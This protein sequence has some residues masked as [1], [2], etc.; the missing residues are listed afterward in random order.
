MNRIAFRTPGRRLHRIAAITLLGLG[1]CASFMDD[2]TS[3][4]FEFKSLYSHP[5]PLVVL[6]DSTDGNERAKALRSL[7]EPKQ[8]GGTD[9]EQDAVVNILVTAASN[10]KQALCRLAAIQS[11][12][13]FQDPRAAQGLVS[14]FDNAGTFAPDTR[15]IV[16]CQA[17]RAMGEAHN[18]AAI[19]RLVAVVR[20]PPVAETQPLAEKRQAL[21]IRIAAARALG[22]F[23]EPQAS[24]ALVTV[25]KT[26]KDVALRDRAQESLVHMTGKELPADAQAWDDYL[27]KSGG[28]ATASAEQPK[29]LKWV[30]FWDK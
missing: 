12:G 14:A 28:T 22:N 19:E 24:Q 11:L 6:R 15:T 20:E 2:I 13:H 17:L 3:R 1:G 4:N 18:P 5:N 8:H 25:L 30:N 10:E 7:Q 16:R 23:K 26:E 29:L 21:E 27:Q 9:T